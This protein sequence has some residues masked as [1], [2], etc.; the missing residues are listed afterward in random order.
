MGQEDIC[1][2]SPAMTLY[3]PPEGRLL[4]V[5]LSKIDVAS[6]GWAAVVDS[7]VIVGDCGEYPSDYY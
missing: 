3:Q 4:L 7:R 1:F 6:I 5:L 2:L